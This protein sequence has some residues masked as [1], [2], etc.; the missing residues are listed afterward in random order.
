[1]ARRHQ[2]KDLDKSIR[3][4]KIIDTAAMLFYKKGYRSTTLGDVAKLL[5]ISKAALYHYVGSKEEILTIIYYQTFETIFRDTHEISDMP[6][7]ADE[8]L[9]RIIRNHIKNIIVR[10]L[11]MFSVFFSEESQLP[12]K[13]SRKIREKKRRY[14]KVLEKIIE[15]GMSQGLFRRVD[16]RLQAY[17]ILGMCNWV[18]KWYKTDQS[19]YSPDEI[20]D[21]FIALLEAG[22]L[23]VKSHKDKASSIVSVRTQGEAKSRDRSQGN[24]EELRR[25]CE[26]MIA[27]IDEMK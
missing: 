12:Q 4:Q 24:L 27:L 1:M 3:K 2:F 23:K 11:S 17:G 19:A 6:L 8:K 16:P 20:A 10:N 7:R 14:T 26:A 5:D 21:T 22:Y 15:E 25:Q 9:R 18:Y 13:D